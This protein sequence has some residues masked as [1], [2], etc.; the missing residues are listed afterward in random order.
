M[1]ALEITDEPITGV[2]AGLSF[3]VD[4]L[5]SGINNVYVFILATMFIGVAIVLAIIGYLI[6]F[7]TSRSLMGGRSI[8][9]TPL[10]LF[11]SKEYERTKHVSYDGTKV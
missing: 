10:S 1:E 3:S 4:F 7:K 8:D 2:L 5:Q 9:D 11:D 6:A